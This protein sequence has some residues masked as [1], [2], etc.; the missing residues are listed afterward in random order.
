MTAGDS[1]WDM[2]AGHLVLQSPVYA[3]IACAFLLA[4]IRR[5]RHPTASLLLML[6]VGLMAAE[7]LA[8]FVFYGW[9]VTALIGA[10]GG[11]PDIDR[12]QR[13]AQLVHGLLVAAAYALIFAAV[14]VERTRPYAPDAGSARPG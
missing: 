14:F 1:F 5:R 7:S 8:A 10:G 13:V 4:L 9:L 12:W 11:S 6:G 2:W 3:V